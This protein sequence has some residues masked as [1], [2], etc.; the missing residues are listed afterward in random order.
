MDTEVKDNHLLATVHQ[1]LMSFMEYKDSKLFFSSI[2]QTKKKRSQSEMAFIF[3]I[4][5]MTLEFN[6]K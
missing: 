5:K 2:L 3:S 6:Y 1:M 4:S